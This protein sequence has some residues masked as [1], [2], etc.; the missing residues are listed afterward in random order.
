MF[1]LLMTS[2]ILK[3]FGLLFI[4]AP[5][6][7]IGLK[8]FSSVVEHQLLECTKF[9]P[10]G[11]HKLGFDARVA[12]ACWKVA[13]GI[14]FTSSAVVAEGEFSFA[15]VPFSSIFMLTTFVGPS[16]MNG[17]ERRMLIRMSSNNGRKSCRAKR[18][19]GNR[20][21]NSKRLPA[22]SQKSWKGYE[23]RSCQSIGCKS[24]FLYRA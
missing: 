15:S 7:A 24:G 22:F 13:S 16:S 17:F 2:P 5:F 23:I 4:A 10:C 12:F 3:R 18:R 20:V 6:V 11:G 8:A 1:R 9:L 21:S 19:K 14:V